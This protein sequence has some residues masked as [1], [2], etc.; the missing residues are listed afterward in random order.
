MVHKIPEELI[1][2]IKSKVDIV[3]IINESVPLKKQGRNYLGLCPFHNEKTPSFSVS[4]EKQIFHCFGC[5]KGGNVISFLMERNNLSFIEVVKNLADRIGISLPSPE[6][7]PEEKAKYDAHAR[8]YKLNELA[9]EFYRFLLTKAEGSEARTYLL[10][11]GL[12]EEIISKF[13]L[14]FAPNKW[15]ELIHLA[16]KRGFKPEE[17]VTLGLASKSE[18]GKIFD[19]FRNRIIFPIFD[20]QGRIIGFGGRVLDDSS[21]KYLNSPETPLFHKGQSLYGINFAKGNIREADEAVIVEGYMDAITCHQYGINNAVASLGTALTPEQSK[22][23]MRYTYNIAISYDGDTAGT[24]ATLRGLGILHGLG[25]KVKV[26]E[27]DDG[28]DPDEVL[29]KLGVESFRK[30]SKHALPLI[31]Y[32]LKTLMKEINY[33][34][35]SGKQQVVQALSEDLRQVISPVVQQSYVELIAKKI[36]LTETALWAEL[37]KTRSRPLSQHQLS[38]R[39]SPERNNI[40]NKSLTVLDKVERELIVLI[41]ENKEILKKVASEGGKELF[42]Q[43]DVKAAY[44]IIEELAVAEKFS[45]ANLLNIVSSETASWISELIF[46]LQEKENK[47]KLFEDYLKAL[48][49]RYIDKQLRILQVRVTELEQK[50]DIKAVLSIIPEIQRLTQAKHSL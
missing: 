50:G 26:I 6:R 45:G 13:K 24:N 47:Q 4:P 2:E 43:E 46:A 18:S 19:R 5:N 28:K 21:P 23:L 27:F 48:K 34:T 33:S 3:E 9:M 30:K 44:D 12:T 36:G 32:K 49:Q 11:R 15:A 29:R 41:L 25:C 39:N 31:E 20:V 38:D 7:S 8:M 22:L 1:E 17:L 10:N 42:F 37:K 16:Q 14:G 35:I 40:K